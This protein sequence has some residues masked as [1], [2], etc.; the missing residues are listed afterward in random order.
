MKSERAAVEAVFLASPILDESE[1]LASVQ[2]F[3]GRVRD[4]YGRLAAPEPRDD[5]A[6]LFR[7]ERSRAVVIPI[8]AARSSWS[9]RPRLRRRVMVLAASLTACAGITTGLAAAGAL[10]DPVQHTVHDVLDRVGI[11]VPSGSS[12]QGQSPSQPASR[13]ISRNGAPA[14]AVDPSTGSASSRSDATVP[15]SPDTKRG[16]T[17][18]TAPIPGSPQAPS[19]ASDLPGALPPLPGAPF[20]LPDLPPVSVP[21]VS[22]PP[23]ESVPPVS[24]PPAPLPVPPATPPPVSPPPLPPP[25]VSVPP[26]PLPGL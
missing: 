6:A 1:P 24:V 14:G 20:P 8:T 13:P 4:T 11:H 21:P 18:T 25:P 9:A 19:V 3:V 12:S 5:L 16:S 17:A 22:E 2:Q 26:L 7:D 23:P 10:P 15:A